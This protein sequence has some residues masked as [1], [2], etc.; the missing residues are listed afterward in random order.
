ML[1]SLHLDPFSMPYGEK[2]VLRLTYS[3]MNVG[4][5]PLVRKSLIFSEL[6]I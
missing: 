4:L 5:R 2:N 1:A 3:Q 6:L